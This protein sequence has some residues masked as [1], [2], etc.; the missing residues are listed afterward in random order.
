MANINKLDN[1]MHCLQTTL[2]KRSVLDHLKETAYIR[3]KSI[4]KSVKHCEITV[5]LHNAQRNAVENARGWRL[6]LGGAHNY[7]N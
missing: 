3:R 2:L 7:A 4:T 1:K 5:N 6:G